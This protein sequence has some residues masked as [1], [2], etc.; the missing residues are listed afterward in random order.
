MVDYVDQKEWGSKTSKGEFVLKDLDTE[1]SAILREPGGKDPSAT[2]F[3]GKLRAF[4]LS[5]NLVGGEVLAKADLERPV[6]AILDPL[7]GS[8]VAGGAVSLT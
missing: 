8:N 1:I 4:S 5:Q 7:L 6:A 2:G 3:R